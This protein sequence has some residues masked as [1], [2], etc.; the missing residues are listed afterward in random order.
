MAREI[1]LLSHAH[2]FRA[3]EQEEAPPGFEPG[4]SDLQSDALATWLR[5]P[6]RSGRHA[7]NEDSRG[8]C[9][10]SSRRLSSCNGSQCF[11]RTRGTT[12]L[13]VTG[14]GKPGQ[15]QASLPAQPPCKLWNE[16]LY[17]RAERHPN[18]MILLSRRRIGYA[19][20]R[21]CKSKIFD[22]SSR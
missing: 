8:A 5:R 16:C 18:P 11:V 12:C 1:S 4:M 3:R 9:Q 19:A 14:L 22:D 13:K 15:V 6:E 21:S 17:G 7:R 20:S 2:Q 10:H